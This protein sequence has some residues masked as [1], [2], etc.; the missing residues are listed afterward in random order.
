MPVTV[1]D[2]I[3]KMTVILLV[4]LS[5]LANQ[6]TSAYA[7]TVSTANVRSASLDSQTITRNGMVRVYLS[8]L[9]NPSRLDVTVKGN[10][11]M[12]PGAVDLPNGAQLTI[13][14][15]SS[16]GNLSVRYNGQTYQMGK[17]FSLF[18]RNS[19]DSNGLLIAQSRD[20]GNPYPGDLSFE[21]VS[22]GN[23]YTLYP[24]A[25]VYI[26][27]YLYGVLPY[28]MGN[29]S[30]IEALKAQAVAARTYTVRMMKSRASGRY[31]VKDTTSDQVYRGTPG[32]NA[33]CVSAVN[34]TKGIVL[35]YGSEYITTY[36]SSS[37]GGQTEVARTGTSYPYMKVKDDPFDYDNPNSAVKKKTVYADLSKSANPSGLIS[38]LKSKALS[39]LQRSG[40]PA[41]ADRTT[42]GVLT[43]ISLHTPMYSFPSKLYTKADFTF[44]ASTWNNA[45]EW[46]T[47]PLTVTCSIFGELESL[48]GMSH[49]PS[50]NELWS[51]QKT[52]DAFVLQARRYGHGMGMSQRG[53]MYMAKLGYSYDEILGFY[54]EGCRRVGH[55]FTHTILT[56]GS[57]DA[58]V[59]VDR[60]A[61]LENG[62]L[63]EMEAVSQQ[64]TVAT[65]SGSL[66]LRRQPDVASGIVT[67][68]PRG[69][70]VEVTARGSTWSAV[71]YISRSGYVMTRYLM[72]AEEEEDAPASGPEQNLQCKARVT[73]PSG[74]LNLRLAP[75]AGSR[76][77]ERIPQYSIVNVFEHGDSWSSVEYTGV[78]GYVMTK[79]LS[80]DVTENVPPS[81]EESK[82]EI[83]SPSGQGQFAYV[84]TA[85]GPLNMRREPSLTGAFITSIPRF[86]EVQVLAYGK[87][88]CVVLY[89]GYEG[90]A[91][92]RYLRFDKLPTEPDV[93][94]GSAM[95]V[96][97]E[98]GPLN[99]RSSESLQGGVIATIPR[100][101]QVEAFERR[102]DWQSVSY[103]VVS[104]FVMS[105]FLTS[106]KPALDQPPLS[107]DPAP[108]AGL[109]ETRPSEPYITNGGVTL[110]VTLELPAS[111][112]YAETLEETTLYLMCSEQKGTATTV[113]SGA[114]VEVLL[115]G[116]LWCKVGYQNEQGYCRT[117][118]LN[119]R[120]E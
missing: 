44:T 47:V 17:K 20:S 57:G 113:P 33:N 119:V 72:F 8:S 93:S 26:E 106:E 69:E 117:N 39:S 95:W 100:Y 6:W 58:D 104:G 45:G 7:A 48:L 25:H 91:M 96:V 27:K 41:T 89:H 5:L 64:A 46:T 103:Q 99:L 77:L 9:G 15:S 52:S 90:Y 78:Q 16:S 110:D 49:Q 55:A 60:P 62:D 51:V 108:S 1:R 50:A 81:E 111:A 76:I 120:Y 92:T 54:Y 28:E 40:Y 14:F 115:V 74:S 105:K 112:A 65:E 114:E 102:G 67:T 43:D 2:K 4:V 66:N 86:A 118:Q 61:D 82:P 85:A 56:G 73:T 11:R 116:Q 36:Y 101:A 30:G 98:S 109:S 87:T 24:I 107:A 34:A 37:N 19:N 35:M 83:S 31:D 22:G 23:G 42:L 38:L 75:N 97:T 29:S 71:Q 32:G 21:A 63:P 68:I 10:Y 12:T 84:Y 13:E 3:Q 79:F 53:A 18:R 70:M 59:T 80:F 94:A 88:W